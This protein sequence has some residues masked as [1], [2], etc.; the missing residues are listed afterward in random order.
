M[1]AAAEAFSDRARN[2][3]KAARA[4][5]DVDPCDVAR[6]LVRAKKG[7][8]RFNRF[9]RALDERARALVKRCDRDDDRLFRGRIAER[10]EVERDLLRVRVDRLFRGPTLAEEI[11]AC[12]GV[13]GERQP[14]FVERHCAE[15]SVEVVATELRDAAR[16][17]DVVASIGEINERRVERASAEVVDDDVLAA[18]VERGLVTV[19]ELDPRGRGL[20]EPL[21][22]STKRDARAPVRSEMVTDT[23]PAASTS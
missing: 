23:T 22:Q 9:E 21:D 18:R 14:S 10:C 8:E 16:R 3:R 4:P 11:G 2:D 13:I 17:L 12:R 15:R 7:D 6:F 19:R 20:V 5:D 1:N